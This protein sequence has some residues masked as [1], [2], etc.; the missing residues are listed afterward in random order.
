[1]DKHL[2]RARDPISLVTTNEKPDDGKTTKN[3][4]NEDNNVMDILQ[5]V[6][7]NKK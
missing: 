7:R 5:F 1:M 6:L 2:R 3:R 4:S